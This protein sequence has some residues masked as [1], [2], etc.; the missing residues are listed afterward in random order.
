MPSKVVRNTAT[1]NTADFSCNLLDNNHQWKT[2]KKSPR[3]RK[4]KLCADLTVSGDATWIIV[5]RP[6]YQAWA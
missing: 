1:S 5:Y 2:K 6:S 4:A 3:K